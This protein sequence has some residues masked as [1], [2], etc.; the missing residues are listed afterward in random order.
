MSRFKN[1]TPIVWYKFESKRSITNLF[2]RELFPT[3]PSPNNMT[4]YIDIL[5]IRRN[6]K[7]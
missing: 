2:I 5:N 3:P 1:S 6:Y 4:C 7:I